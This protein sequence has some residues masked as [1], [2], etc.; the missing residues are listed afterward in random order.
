MAMEKQKEYCKKNN[1]PM[2]APSDGICWSC[3]K[4]I[5]DTDKELITGCSRCN[6]SYCE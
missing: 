4:L 5:N 6:R 2:F 1:Q 3:G